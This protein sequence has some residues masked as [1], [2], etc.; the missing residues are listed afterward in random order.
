PVPPP[1]RVAP[2]PLGRVRAV[3]YVKERPF[4]SYTGEL[5]RALPGIAAAGFNTVWLVLPWWQFEPRPLA[6]P[7]AYDERSFD[8]LRRVL[9]DLAGRNMH[10]IIGLDY[11]GRGWAPMGIDACRWLVTPRYEN[12][13]ERYV[14][15]FL[16]RI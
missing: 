8:A 11:L 12:A 9:N 10:A 5:R 14:R 4:A 7:P 6:T 15:G 13:F 2:L 3:T 1:A 16:E